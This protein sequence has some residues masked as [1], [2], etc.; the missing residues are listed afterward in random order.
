[1]HKK[2]HFQNATVGTGCD[3]SLLWHF[4]NK[5][6]LWFEVRS[7]SMLSWCTSHWLAILLFYLFHTNHFEQRQALSLNFLD[8]LYNGN[9]C[10]YI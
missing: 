6:M 2:D 8:C 9:H 3:L 1:L 10:P 7:L 5:H 4:E